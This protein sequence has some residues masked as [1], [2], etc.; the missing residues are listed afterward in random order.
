[1][2]QHLL[3]KENSLHCKRNKSQAENMHS[4]L[5]HHLGCLF[6]WPRSEPEG[7][8]GRCSLPWSP[9]PGCPQ[10]WQTAPQFCWHRWCLAW[11]RKSCQSRSGGYRDIECPQELFWDQPGIERKDVILTSTSITSV[12]S[13]TLC[14]SLGVF[15]STSVSVGG[16]VPSWKNGVRSELRS[17][18]VFREG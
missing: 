5:W 6:F 17:W 3:A 4:L 14:R 8:R 13:Q 12:Q 1:M 16:E 7:R 2:A 9:P 10:K 15:V 11:Q 18:I